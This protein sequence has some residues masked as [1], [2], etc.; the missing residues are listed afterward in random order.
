MQ[1]IK[2]GARWALVATLALSLTGPATFAQEVSGSIKG[3]VLTTAG[4]AIPGVLVTLTGDGFPSGQPVVTNEKG[5][6]RY[7]A[8][9][10][11]PL[12]APNQPR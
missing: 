11:G 7:P 9:P 10:S 3:S 8:V 2:L 6:Y 4:E 5:R 1:R 12:H